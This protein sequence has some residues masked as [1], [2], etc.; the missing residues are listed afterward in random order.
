MPNAKAR[1]SK[2]IQRTNDKKNEKEWND[3]TLEYWVKQKNFSWI[4]LYHSIISP[5]QIFLFK[6]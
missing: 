3:G 6:F 5:L 4:F 2:E 1:S